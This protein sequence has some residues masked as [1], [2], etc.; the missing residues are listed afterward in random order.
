MSR[1][2]AENL[3]ALSTVGFVFREQMRIFFQ[4]GAAACGVGDDGV[5]IVGVKSREVCASQIARH[6]ADTGVRGKRAAA[7]LFGGDDDFAA[8]CLQHADGGAIEFAESNLRHAAGEE[9]DSGAL[10]SLGRESL[11]QLAEEEIR[12]DLWQQA[13]AVLQ[14]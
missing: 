10:L 13:L 7:N 6:V 5:E 8:V 9:R 11:S 2:F 3:R 4:R 1:T 14:A 12:V